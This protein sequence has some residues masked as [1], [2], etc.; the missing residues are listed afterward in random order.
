MVLKK[1]KYGGN[2]G[3]T[4]RNL[5]RTD[6]INEARDSVFI[7]E[8]SNENI[9]HSKQISNNPNQE[10]R[11]VRNV[12]FSLKKRK[13]WQL[14]GQLEAKFGK[15]DKKIEIL[16]TL[17]Y[18]N[19][20]Y[21]RARMCVSSVKDSEGRSEQN[22]SFKPNNIRCDRDSD[23]DCQFIIKKPSMTATYPFKLESEVRGSNFKRKYHKDRKYN[24]GK[25]RYG[26][27]WDPRIKN[28]MTLRQNVDHQV[29]ENEQYFESEESEFNADDEEFGIEYSYKEQYLNLM[30]LKL[31]KDSEIKS[32]PK[33]KKAKRKFNRNLL[34]EPKEKH[35]IEI[36]APVSSIYQE[37]SDK[38]DNV[39]VDNSVIVTFNNDSIEQNLLHDVYGQFYVEGQTVQR[40]FIIMNEVDPMSSKILFEVQS[41]SESIS[42]FKVTFLGFDGDLDLNLLELFTVDEPICFHNFVDM[43]YPGLSTTDTEG[44]TIPLKNED[45]KVTTKSESQLIIDSGF[46]H[47]DQAEYAS[48]LFPTATECSSCFNEIS[49]ETYTTTLN[50]CGHLFCNECWK[51]YLKSKIT[52]GST[53]NITCLAYKCESV[54]DVVTLLSKVT[55]DLFNLYVKGYTKQLIQK[56]KNIESC[57]NND[58]KHV[59]IVDESL[60]PHV[61][62]ASEILS[63]TLEV[64]CGKCHRSWCF[65]CKKTAHWPLSCQ[66]YAKLNTLTERLVKYGNIDST[67]RVLKTNVRGKHCPRCGKFIEKNGGCYVMMCIC[68]NEGFCWNCTTPFNE[69][70]N[71]CQQST[72]EYAFM[73]ILSVKEKRLMEVL[74]ESNSNVILNRL[75]SQ[76]SNRKLTFKVM[77]YQSALESMKILKKS[78]NV[79][80]MLSISKLVEPK[81]TSPKI[82]SYCRRISFSNELLIQTLYRGIY[83][84]KM[85]TDEL[86]LH[87]ADIEN[88]LKSISA[89]IKS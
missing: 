42:T 72:K 17:P 48:S 9:I 29:F 25:W 37:S 63:R 51:E 7:Q 70:G 10:P 1:S 85:N 78:I 83:S 32:T 23:A 52:N 74:T 47:Y 27:V 58:C 69:H 87:T 76:I 8:R 68:S 21:R 53:K 60:I 38:E 64:Q 30:E 61:P 81:L 65:T 40:K 77:F 82:M 19:S 55:W 54:I 15:T 75:W 44:P 57:P 28:S 46:Y 24:W 3:N 67:G 86:E 12:E 80:R 73:P 88:I 43:F 18:Y 59:V 36:E 66:T 13:N 16:E 26:G 41:T 62:K 39:D 56:S 6:F 20:H 45:E 33:V 2:T 31:K 34:V 5:F 4:L 11:V 50:K 14:Q 71:G 22:Y 84:G 79:L 49:S 35:I 89:N